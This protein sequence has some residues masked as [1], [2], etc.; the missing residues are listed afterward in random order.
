MRAPALPARSYWRLRR[1]LTFPPDIVV[2]SRLLI[3]LALALATAAALQHSPLGGA[4]Q[5]GLA[6]LE[7]DPAR[8]ALIAALT[9]CCLAALIAG[10]LT[11]R[12][13]PSALAG[14]A[15]LCMTYALPWAWRMAADR[16]VLFGTPER[17]N[18]IALAHNLS[19]IAA[20]AVVLAVPAAA[21]GRVL[22]D[23][24]ILPP[25]L[26][27][28]PAGLRGLLLSA[29]AGAVALSALGVEPLLRYGPGDQVYLPATPSA[30]GTTG[31]VLVRTIH[32]AALGA[33]RPLAIYLP[34]SYR[35]SPHVRYPVVYLLHGSPGGYRDWLNLGIA[36]ISDA[37][38]A[39]GS[40]AEAI[41]V[42]PDGN[43]RL[44]RP[45]QWADSRDGAER[46]E[47]SM[48]ELVSQIDREYRTLAD[49]RH[50][51]VAG[52]SEGGFGAVN[53]ASRHPDL[54]GAAISLSGYFNAEGLAF[55]GS[56]T[57]IHA[58]SPTSTVQEQPAAR[59]VRFLLVAGESDRP[60]L[61]SAE[62]FASELDRFGVPHQLFRVPG[63]HESLVWTNGL[64]LG[65]VELKP[66]LQG[67]VR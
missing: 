14:I 17:L 9:F 61:R 33:E 67:R 52:L 31:Q 2:G 55:G 63:G 51:V 58:N 4:L 1:T 57:L 5:A 62:A 13:W 27:A 39:S 41:I 50:R 43:G 53:L 25:Q 19:T 42:M 29:F 40:L 18:A 12:P 36:G 65:L 66:Q 20:L 11:A 7:L 15:Y 30:A 21:T 23:L 28:P 48:V 60:Y 35:L 45:T 54:F 32:S 59:S 34:P 49:R 22:S 38:I 64:V 6:S 24:V 16:P 56:Q 10:A 37:G 47:S 44:N 26:P 8:V 46:M 3:G